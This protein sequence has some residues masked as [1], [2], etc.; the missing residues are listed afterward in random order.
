MFRLNHPGILR[1]RTS[2]S[3]CFFHIINLAVCFG[4]LS[5]WNFQFNAIL[6]C[7]RERIY[8]AIKSRY[9]PN[10]KS[11]SILRS[12]PTKLQEVQSKTLE[13]SGILFLGLPQILIILQHNHVVKQ[14]SIRNNIFHTVIGLLRSFLSEI[15]HKK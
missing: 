10:V 2:G 6:S 12:H 8:V 13:N 5:C 7:A 3:R 14:S 15:C 4:S 11:L 1:I 9:L